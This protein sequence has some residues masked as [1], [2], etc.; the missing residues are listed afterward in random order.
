M[1]R[2][3]VRSFFDPATRTLSHVAWDADTRAAAIIDS[4]LDYDEAA[5]RI[6]HASAAAILA[7]VDENGLRVEWIIDTH[8]HA[9]HLSAAAYLRERVG[10]K[11]A[12]GAGVR[13]AQARFARLFDLGT[14]FATDGSQFDHLFEDGERYR[15]GGI[16]A[17]ALH[18]PG[19]TPA[20]MS[21]LIGDALFVGDT[22]F[23]PDY[24]SARCDFP[25]GDAHALYRS[26]RRLFALPETTRMFLC[27]DYPVPG[28]DGVMA[29]TTVGAQRQDNVHL[30]A[31]TDEAEFVRMRETRD[32]TLS[33]PRLLLPAVQVNIRAGSLPPPAANGIRYLKIPLDRL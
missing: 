20:C 14:D 17:V 10:G 33:V 9:D 5:G 8:V 6:G 31:G 29:E 18:T 3:G 23:S 11:I 32:A 27:H 19:H 12:I 7:F 1:T 25:G 30:R 16:D 2:P 26:S 28:R 24:G 22:L 21:H 15:L 13:D 4:V